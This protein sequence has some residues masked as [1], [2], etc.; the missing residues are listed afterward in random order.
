MIRLFY[1]IHASTTGAI[2]VMLVLLS[3][4]VPNYA[5]KP[6][7][8]IRAAVKT[9]YNKA[10]GTVT[11]LA[12]PIRTTKYNTQLSEYDYFT[13]YLRGWKGPTGTI[14]HHQLYV[15]A[16]YTDAYLRSYRSAYFEGN[17]PASFM[18]IS[19]RLHG[20]RLYHIMPILCDFE[21]V[22][23]VALTTEFLERHKTTGL[24]VQV[25]AQSGQ[26]VSIHLPSSYVQGYLAAVADAAGRRE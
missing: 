2:F 23:G 16:Q 18:Q 11:L 7:A 10:D 5:E 6:A 3:G 19:N 9:E 1:S 4:C 20:C 13:A 8:E 12:P 24:S 17:Q 15:D 21:E 26:A 14:V 25:S 22:F